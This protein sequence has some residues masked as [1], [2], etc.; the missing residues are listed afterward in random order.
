M[1]K[2]MVRPPSGGELAISAEQKRVFWKQKA[3]DQEGN[4]KKLTKG[5]L[6]HLLGEPLWRLLLVFLLVGS[7]SFPLI[8]LSG[9]LR[10]P[11]PELRCSLLENCDRDCVGAE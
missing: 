7:P 1:V 2:S 8:L 3:T 10:P 11:T 5:L 4:M 6:N 9:G